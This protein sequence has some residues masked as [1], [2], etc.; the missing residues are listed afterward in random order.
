MPARILAG[1]L[2]A[3]ALLGACGEPTV[4]VAPGAQ[5]T[6]TGV[7]ADLTITI[8]DGGGATS[9]S[10]LTCRPAGGNHPDPDAACAAL[11]AAWPKA[12]EPPDP[13]VACTEIYGGPETATVSGTIDGR[14]VDA[15]FSSTDGCQIARWD[16]VRALL[17]VSAR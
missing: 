14:R 11:A 9:T 8:D 5:P 15:S 16:A 17:A 7:P 13:D 2:L 12:F 1:S 3:L 6:G 4:V 10:T